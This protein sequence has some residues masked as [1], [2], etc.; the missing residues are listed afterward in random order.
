MITKLFVYEIPTFNTFFR[1]K[2]T[3]DNMHTIIQLLF[4]T[5]IMSDL[6][7]SYTLIKLDLVLQIQ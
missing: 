6:K 4:C 7:I 2:M 3:L 5:A 1:L